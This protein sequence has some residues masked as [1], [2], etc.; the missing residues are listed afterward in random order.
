MQASSPYAVFFRV[1][2]FLSPKFS[3]TNSFDALSRGVGGSRAFLR[4]S[5]SISPRHA[6]APIASLMWGRVQS[7]RDP[8]SRGEGRTLIPKEVR[9]FEALGFVV[10]V[11]GSSGEGKMRSCVWPTEQRYGDCRGLNNYLYYFGGSLLRPR[12]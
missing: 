2:G 12:D 7:R 10:L 6:C 1:E 5:A 11:R 3:T 4:C 8:H 9:D